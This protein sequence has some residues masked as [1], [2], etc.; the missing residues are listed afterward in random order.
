MIAKL[1]FLQKLSRIPYKMIVNF[2]IAGSKV[3]RCLL[4]AAGKGSLYK[5]DSHLIILIRLNPN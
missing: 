5:G 3:S 4:N 2:Y 1:G